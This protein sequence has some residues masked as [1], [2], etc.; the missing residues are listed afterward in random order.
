VCG[1]HGGLFDLQDGQNR[2]GDIGISGAD[3]DQAKRQCSECKHIEVV[4]VVGND[5][6]EHFVVDLLV[7]LAGIRIAETEN[8][9]D[10]CVLVSGVDVVSQKS[11]G[12]IV[13][14]MYTRAED[15]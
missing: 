12:W 11:Q 6:A 3:E 13:F 15:T 9:A 10:A 4:V 5:W 2:L 14:A 8:G 1:F 7:R